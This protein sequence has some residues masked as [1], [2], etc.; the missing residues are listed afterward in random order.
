MDSWSVGFFAFLLA[1]S[2]LVWIPTNSMEVTMQKSAIIN[3]VA[4]RLSYSRA[5]ARF[6]GPMPEDL[7]KAAAEC[8]IAIAS[9]ISKVPN[10]S[11]EEA[12]QMNTMLTES[13]LP[14]IE[15]KALM[16]VIDAKVNMASA[17]NHTTTRQHLPNPEHWQSAK[18]WEKYMQDPSECTTDDKLMA[19]ANRLVEV[20]ALKLNEISIAAAAA[21][22][23]SQCPGA[24]PLVNTRQ[25][26]L[27]YNSISKEGKLCGP[28]HY[29]TDIESLRLSHSQLWSAIEMDGAI[30]GRV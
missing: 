7:D 5:K 30:P 18:C 29:P 20:G 9:C 26:K 28:E 25:L 13:F 3:L 19:M 8:R 15:Q 11:I 17:T 14:A 21:I 16:E 2:C 10:V 1:Q 27:F 23:S 4:S 6:Q 22:A 24:N 12:S